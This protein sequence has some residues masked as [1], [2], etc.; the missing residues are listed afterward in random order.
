MIIQKIHSTPITAAA[1]KTLRQP[2][3]SPK[4]LPNGAAITSAIET[5]PKITD[6]AFGTVRGGTRRMVS[7]ADI[8]QNPPSASPRQARPIKSK[9]NEL[10]KETSKQESVSKTANKITTLRRSV[11]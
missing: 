9:L 7:D 3:S 8:A 5:A 10:A 4:K 6:S 1:L 2:I 11:A